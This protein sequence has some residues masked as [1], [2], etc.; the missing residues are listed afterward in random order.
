MKIKAMLASMVAV[1]MLTACEDLFEDGSMQP[2][3]SNPSL[4]VNNPSNNQAVTA[5]SGLRVNVTAVDKDKF[6]EI[7][8][9][10]TSQNSDKAVVSFKKLSDKNVVV[11]DTTLNM[12]GVAPGAYTLK[13]S[14]TDKRTNLSEQNVLVNVK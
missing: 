13:I 5:T 14:A 2:D 6:N 10:L 9:V 12:T 1:C 7:N 4:T 8:F 3:G 11:V